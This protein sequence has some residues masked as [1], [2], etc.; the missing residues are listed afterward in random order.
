MLTIEYHGVAIDFARR[1]DAAGSWV[2]VVD[3]WIVDRD[4]MED[5]SESRIVQEF[6][7]KEA[8]R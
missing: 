4:A 1:T 6:L 5:E 8:L 2:E 7:T 3:H